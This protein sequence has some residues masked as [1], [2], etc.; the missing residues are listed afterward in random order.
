MCATCSAKDNV[1]S[2][3]GREVH[4]TNIDADIDSTDTARG[5]HRPQFQHAVVAA[6]REALCVRRAELYRPTALI[7]LLQSL[8]ST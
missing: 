8:I 1:I 7:V 5:I 4:A 2:V 6:R 3:V